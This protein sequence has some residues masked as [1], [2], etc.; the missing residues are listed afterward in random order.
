MNKL[1]L[2]TFSFLSLLLIESCKKDTVVG[3]AY[4]T[5]PF[6]ANINGSTWAPKDTLSSTITYSSAT[7]T[8]VFALSGTRDQEQVL[9]S[10]AISAGNTPGFVLGTYN[11]DG[12][13]VTAQFNTLQKDSLGN[14][15]YL[16]H[17]SVEPGAGIINIT[18]IDSVKKQIT[19]TFSFYS[20]STGLDSLGN[21]TITI[22]NILGGEFTSLPYTYQSN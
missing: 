5:A 9:L 18:A 13:A 19:G 16:P 11:V 6:Q 14:Y 1:R 2:L 7:G 4:T 20:R 22:D 8:K 21:T 10:V 15:V 12:T 17:G 3:T